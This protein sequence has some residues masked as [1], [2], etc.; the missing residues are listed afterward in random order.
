MAKDNGLHS[1]RNPTLHPATHSV[2]FYQILLNKFQQQR[3]KM[4]FDVG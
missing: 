1:K 2:S 4:K 3:K